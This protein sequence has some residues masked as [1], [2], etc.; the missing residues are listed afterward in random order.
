MDIYGEAGQ[1]RRQ[2]AE[3]VSLICVKSAGTLNYSVSKILR[4]SG[5]FCFGSFFVA[6]NPAAIQFRY[7]AGM[8]VLSA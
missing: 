4:R 5:F 8:T 1:N 2:F 7:E 6:L 3:N